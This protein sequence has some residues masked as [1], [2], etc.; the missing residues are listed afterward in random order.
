[1]K[2]KKFVKAKNYLEENLFISDPILSKALL[3]IKSM[4][5][6]FLHSSFFDGSCVET[7]LL[8][9]FVEKQVNVNCIRTKNFRMTSFHMIDCF[10]QMTNI[11]FICL[12]RIIYL[13]CFSVAL[14]KNFQRLLIVTNTTN[15]DLE[16]LE[17]S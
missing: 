13:D 17:S 16:S 7:L 9:Y 3:E 10:T 12:S 4:C 1:M 14:L 8:F 2:Y 11:N 5:S 6:I 15:F